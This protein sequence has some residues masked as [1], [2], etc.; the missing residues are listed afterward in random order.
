MQANPARQAELVHDLPDHVDRMA[1]HVP[2]EGRHTW[3]AAAARLLLATCEAVGPR[4]RDFVVKTLRLL[5]AWLK[6]AVWWRHLCRE[7]FVKGQ[8]E[9]LVSYEEKAPADDALAAERAIVRV[10]SPSSIHC[11][12]GQ[13]SFCPSFADW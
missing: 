8:R 6:R 2:V 9:M 10:C 1:K 12:D 3:E 11:R 7:A 5:P 13:R 4:G